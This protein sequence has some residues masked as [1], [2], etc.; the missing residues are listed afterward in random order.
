M[1]TREESTNSSILRFRLG[2]ADFE[3]NR[4][5]WSVENLKLD[6]GNP[7]LGYLLRQHKKAPHR[8]R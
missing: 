3:V 8:Q 4:E 6:P 5:L 1:K 7:R 2:N